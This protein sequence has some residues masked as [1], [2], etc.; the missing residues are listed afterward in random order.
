MAE[1]YRNVVIGAGHMGLA[2]IR[3]LLRSDDASSILIVERDAARRAA[4][5]QQ[6]GLAA[7]S[8]LDA[9]PGDLLVLAIPPQAFSEF[10]AAEAARL[11][12]EMAVVSVMAGITVDTI[13][14]LLGTHQ[15]VRTIPNT[16]AEI[17]QGVTV[18]YAPPAVSC[19]TLA[20]AEH[21]LAAIGTSLRVDDEGMIDAATALCGGGPA[22]VSYIADAFCEYAQAERF[23]PHD[24]LRLAAEVF[25]GTAELIAVSGRSPRALCREV[26]T[27]SG[28][29]ERG[30]ARFEAGSVKTIVIEALAAATARSRELS[31]NL[32][33]NR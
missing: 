32:S 28:T 1:P 31:Q 30:I 7:V 26:M 2:I 13:E 5:L 21:V 17:A 6:H 20:R 18:Y 24:A 15:V 4:L 27:P 11:P 23:S 14:G 10:A 3:G 29:T 8:S 9:A 25:R 16:P 22:F 33:L 12:R 19:A